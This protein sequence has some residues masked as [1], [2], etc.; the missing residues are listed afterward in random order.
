M[1]LAELQRT[2]FSVASGER[3]AG[4]ELL[5]MLAI[6]GGASPARRL[7]VYTDTVRLKPV[8]GLG[9]P[10]AK[11]ETLLGAERFAELIDAH[12][13]S[14]PRPQRT[15]D[16]LIRDLPSFLDREGKP[17]GRPDIGALAALDL[18]RYDVSA[19]AGSDAATVDALAELTPR[20]WPAAI[21]SF[22]PAL[23]VL[24][25]PFDVSGLWQRLDDGEPPPPPVASATCLVVWRVGFGVCHSVLEPAEAEALTRA[26]SGTPLA[27]VCESF[28]GQQEPDES[29][30]AALHGWFADGLVQ[31]VRPALRAAASDGE[32]A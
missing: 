29:A 21:L 13:A 17:W 16:N 5:D 27:E 26:R 6:R 7:Q 3:E 22:I 4:P 23:R 32:R 9:V 11:V 2:F 10:F 19:E 1:K 31:A 30:Y 8:E 12:R 18:A 25:L 28:A 20:D 15:L 24:A 14:C